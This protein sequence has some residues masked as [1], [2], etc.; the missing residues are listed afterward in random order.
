MLKNEIMVSD[1]EKKSK[2][3]FSYEQD[4][5]LYYA[6]M[7]WGTKPKTWHKENC[8]ISAVK[9]KNNN[10]RVIVRRIKKVSSIFKHN[11][12]R[13]MESKLMITFDAAALP[14]LEIDEVE[15]SQKSEHDTKKNAKKETRFYIQFDNVDHYYDPDIENKEEDFKNKKIKHPLKNCCIWQLADGQKLDDSAISD[16]HKKLKK[17]KDNPPNKDFEVT[18]TDPISWVFPAI[19][20]PRLD[21]WKNF[22]RQVHCDDNGEIKKEGVIDVEVSIVF[23]DEH[24]RRH[25]IVNGFYKL[26]RAIMYGRIR[27]VE[28]FHIRLD[29]ENKLPITFSFPNIYSREFKINDDDKHYDK[30]YQRTFTEKYLE[31]IDRVKNK[32]KEHTV[33]FEKYQDRKIELFYKQ[34][35]HPVVFVNTSNHAMAG[36]DNNPELWKW[37][38]VAW[39]KLSPAYFGDLPRSEIESIYQLLRD[40]VKKTRKI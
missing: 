14:D 6:P 19:Y 32:F 33:T 35:E 37:E 40:K 1:K 3:W 7:V 34:K 39:E 16:I 38:Y 28:S 12:G 18:R 24:L 5:I 15:V 21:M 23:N 36:H 29:K 11:L 22:I 2:I 20:Q 30:D 17:V 4:E 26:C 25:F 10:L 27:D 8:T 31:P 13:E 9:L